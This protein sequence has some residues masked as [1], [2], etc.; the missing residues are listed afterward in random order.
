MYSQDKEHETDTDARPQD[1]AAKWEAYFYRLSAEDITEFSAELKRDFHGITAAEIIDAIRALSK[2]E[3]APRVPKLRHL[4][5]QIR[6]GRRN[7]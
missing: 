7:R 3:D 2:D 5:F 6:A 4:M 1:W